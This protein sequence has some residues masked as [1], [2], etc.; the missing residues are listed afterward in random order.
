MNTWRP[1]FKN[2]YA[3]GWSS[4]LSIT[5]AK[6][7]GGL[8]TIRS[9]PDIYCWG[10]FFKP[11]VVQE[12]LCLLCFPIFSGL[13]WRGLFLLHA[14]SLAFLSLEALPWEQ[15]DSQPTPGQL[16]P[17]REGT[18]PA[19]TNTSL[20]PPHFFCKRLNWQ[21]EDCTHWNGRKAYGHVSVDGHMPTHAFSA[22]SLP[23]ALTLQLRICLVSL[24]PGRRR[25]QSS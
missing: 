20:P 9:C 8:V 3:R 7:K 15:T 1:K 18:F 25:G 13:C 12:W 22:F 2:H 24:H 10:A 6:R 4:H 11:I 16:L 5:G 19:N 14:A 17:G 21:G 23:F